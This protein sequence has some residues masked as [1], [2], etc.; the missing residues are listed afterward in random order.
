[1]R[2]PLSGVAS[3]AKPV[4]GSKLSAPAAE[5]NRDAIIQILHRF[6]PSS[7]I[8]LELASGTGQHIIA[9]AEA[10]PNLIWQPTDIDP[11]R[12][13]SIDAWAKE[14]QL[15]NL[16]TARPLD[17]A[18]SGWGQV[19]AG[20]NAVL[21]INLLHL[22]SANEAQC[23]VQ[24]AGQALAPGGMLMIYGPF[25]R[26]GKTTS[27]GDQIFHSRLQAHDPETGYKDHVDVDDW[28]RHVGL[29]SCNMVEMPANNL[30]L[31]WQ[32]PAI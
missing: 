8:V 27:D 30:F 14:A 19:H 17:A 16:N 18:S 24:E 4:E 11:S 3:V 26:G 1:M 5:R 13:Q 22:I 15:P 25:L 23:I 32:K 7:G 10:F 12:R 2:K 31:T 29:Q 9:F 21:L 6:L 28:G 20:Q